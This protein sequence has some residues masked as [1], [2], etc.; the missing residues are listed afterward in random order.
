[1]F[2]FLL[3]NGNLRSSTIFGS[4][5]DWKLLLSSFSKFETLIFPV[6]QDTPTRFE[7]STETHASSRLSPQMYSDYEEKRN[8][9]ETFCNELIISFLNEKLIEFPSLLTVW[10]THLYGSIWRFTCVVGFL[11]TAVKNNFTKITN[12]L[13]LTMVKLLILRY[14]TKTWTYWGCI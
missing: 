10:F 6:E 11:V 14:A 7:M 3:A 2:I 8:E 5:R 4:L 12:P 1:M 13:L 9:P